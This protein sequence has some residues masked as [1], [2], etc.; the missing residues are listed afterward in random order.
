[1][2]D[3]FTRLTKVAG[4]L[5]GTGILPVLFAL[6]GYSHWRDA[7]GTQTLLLHPLFAAEEQ[8]E[9]LLMRLDPQRRA[10]VLMALL[11]LVLVGVALVAMAYLG[12]RYL[13]RMI[14]QPVRST[15]PRDDDW[16]RKPLIPPE[17]ASPQAHEPE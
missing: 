3:F 1:M 6:P 15:R 5:G 12:G 16:A 7:S 10:K 14:K 11:G 9:P 13:R 17:P 4:S 2:V 8:A